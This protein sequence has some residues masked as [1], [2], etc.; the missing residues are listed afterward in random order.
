MPANANTLAFLPRSH[1]RPERIHH[2]GHFMPWDARIGDSWPPAFDDDRITVAHT[3]CMNFDAHLSRAWIGNLQ[4]D[5]SKTGSSRSH[6]RGFHGCYRD[7]CRCHKSLL[8]LHSL[9]ESLDT[10]ARL[11]S[12]P[13]SSPLSIAR[14]T[15]T[16]EN[17]EESRLDDGV[18]D[19]LV[20]VP[21]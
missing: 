8:S 1:P 14:K 6:L 21:R 12:L 15:I 4:F 19:T 3:T 10:L 9:L 13:V 11:L 2:A 18:D 7:T 20:L 16:S 17:E 5:D